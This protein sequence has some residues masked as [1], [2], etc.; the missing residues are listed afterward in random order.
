MFDTSSF[1]S[2]LDPK[3]KEPDAQFCG[4]ILRICITTHRMVLVAAPALA[5]LLRGPS[6]DRLPQLR[7]WSVVAFDEAC[8]RLLAEK[9]PKTAL[10][11]WKSLGKRSQSGIK[12][13]AMIAAC[14]ARHK[15]E[16]F[17]SGDGQQRTIATALGC[18]TLAPSE[19]ADAQQTLPI[20]PPRS[21]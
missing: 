5:E 15:A 4:E 10:A 2:G 17:I 16:L 8:A 12:F 14:A 9:A 18:V 7:N 11:Q 6:A 3:S 13:D 1:V 20:P 19:L 21:K